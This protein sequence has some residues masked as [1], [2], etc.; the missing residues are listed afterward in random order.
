MNSVD[1]CTQFPLA[2]YSILE[3]LILECERIHSLMASVYKKEYDAYGLNYLY[4]SEK[5]LVYEMHL[6]L[7]ETRRMPFDE[8]RLAILDKLKS[9]VQK[10]S[11]VTSDL[12]LC[13][14]AL[15]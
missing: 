15:V 11:K 13:I 5:R 1:A 12:M 6:L 10:K 9:L 2:S 7:D 14:N 8:E 4:Q 3:D